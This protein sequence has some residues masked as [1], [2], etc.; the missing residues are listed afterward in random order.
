MT[1]V[2]VSGGWR[3]SGLKP[4]ASGCH[5]LTH[6][7]VTARAEDER[8]LFLVDVERGAEPIAGTW[9]AV[10]MAGTDSGT[11]AIETEVADNA[12]VADRGRYLQRAGFWHGAAGVAACWVG[13]A[14]GVARPLFAAG[15]RDP[16]AAAHT[17]AVD[18]ALAAAHSLLAD[19]AARI[20]ADPRDERREA[21]LWAL[22]LRAV[23]EDAART[24]L[25]QVG[26]ALGASPL[27]LD[28]DHSRRVADLTVYLRQS[29][30][31]ADL[32]RLAR[33]RAGDDR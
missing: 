4:F 7:L 28:A 20:D 23:A 25:D 16:H 1:A 5:T 31:E 33:V 32:A 30:A 18:A 15:G 21:E 13:G 3:L 17:G 9:P 24:T 2:R 22:R 6:A 26:R 11:V 8:L 10:G 27:C 19:V 14:R 29:H 12:L